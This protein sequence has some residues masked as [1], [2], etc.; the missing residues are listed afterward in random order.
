M[1]HGA[2]PDHFG[3]H[4]LGT[5]NAHVTNENLPENI[6]WSPFENCFTL[7]DESGTYM[8]SIEEGDLIIFAVKDIETKDGLISII[9]DM[10]RNATGHIAKEDVQED[11]E[12][13]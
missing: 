5:F 11:A 6:V 10:K 2:Y 3:L 7:V 13:S 4:V 8:R 12:M 1:V 9:G